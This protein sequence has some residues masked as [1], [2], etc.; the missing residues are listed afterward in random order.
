MYII[1]FHLILIDFASILLVKALTVIQANS[2]YSSNRNFH[3]IRPS[4]IFA[5]PRC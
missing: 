5:A 2:N 4:R 1:V 3:I